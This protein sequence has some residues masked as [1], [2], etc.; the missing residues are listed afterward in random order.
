MGWL[1]KEQ[2]GRKL[3]KIFESVGDVVD[4]D[5]K[6]EEESMGTDLKAE[7]PSFNDQD[8]HPPQ[9]KTHGWW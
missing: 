7:A 1:R 3:V 4:L 8:T 6:A 5:E 2:G 9:P